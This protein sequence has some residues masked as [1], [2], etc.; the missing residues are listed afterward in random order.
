[1]V[2]DP[3]APTAQRTNPTRIFHQ[4]GSGNVLTIKIMPLRSGSA[5]YSTH[6]DTHSA[7]TFVIGRT[8]DCDVVIA[9]PD[10]SRRHAQIRVTESDII[11]EDLASSHGVFRDGERVTR[12]RWRPGQNIRIAGFDLSY[13]IAPDSLQ[14][15]AYASTQLHSGYGAPDPMARSA[16]ARR[17]QPAKRSLLN[18][19]LIFT[20]GVAVATLTFLIVYLTVLKDDT[21]VTARSEAPQRA[22]AKPPPPPP[23]KTVATTP[24]ANRAQNNAA[25]DTPAADED[26]HVEKIICT[27]LRRQ[28]LITRRDLTLC[29]QDARRRLTQAHLRGYHVWAKW[30]VLHMRRSKTATHFWHVAARRRIRHIEYLNGRRQRDDVMGRVLCGMGEPL[31]RVLGEFVK[32]Q[33]LSM[34]RFDGKQTA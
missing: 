25:S 18:S 21:P 27:E 14:T 7:S 16:R 12:A 28:D 5:P 10:V 9:S 8:P 23:P 20:S 24:P 30:V 13:E 6:L 22:T 33:D 11:I 29:Q 19:I 34:L 1:M 15:A 17:V 26:Y 32:D 4:R 2:V 3:L 31:C